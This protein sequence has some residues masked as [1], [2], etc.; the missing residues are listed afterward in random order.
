MRLYAVDGLIDLLLRDD[1]VGAIGKGH[2]DKAQVGAR[3]RGG[4][5]D[6]RNTLNSGLDRARDVLVNYF[7]RSAGV[8]SEHSQLR[9]LHTGCQFLLEVRQCKPSEDGY[10]DGHQRNEGAVFH[11]GFS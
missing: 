6:T 7:W 4:V 5:F 2:R 10:N 3:G 8:D 1:Q 11:T 9:E